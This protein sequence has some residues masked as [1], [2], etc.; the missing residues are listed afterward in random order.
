MYI[1]VSTIAHACLLAHPVCTTLLC[2]GPQKNMKVGLLGRMKSFRSVRSVVSNVSFRSAGSGSSAPATDGK[3]G[4]S[5]KD[6]SGGGLWKAISRNRILQPTAVAH[7]GPP[8]KVCMYV[9]EMT[10][11]GCRQAGTWRVFVHS[12]SHACTHT[13]TVAARRP[14]C[15]KRTRKPHNTASMVLRCRKP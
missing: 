11:Q 1:S 13:P 4:A 14:K 15:P 10:S 3:D 5:S 2:D 6:K 9:H 8:L 12:Q 7:I